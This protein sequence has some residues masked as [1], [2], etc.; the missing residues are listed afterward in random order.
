MITYQ[1]ETWEDYLRDCQELWKEHYDEIAVQKEKMAMKPFVGF[2][3]SLEKMGGL[4][5]I[6]VRANGKMV[7]YHITFIRPHT[8]YSDV[9]CGYVDAYFL[10]APYRKG[11]TGVKMIKEAER[12][13]KKRGVQK[14]FS[15]TKDFKNM[16]RIFEYLGWTLIEYA[17]AKYIGD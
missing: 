11:M 8:H 12:T 16:S 2:Y 6:T 4:H 15:A 1:V 17:F 3:E 7:G 10:S 9:L 14:M 5:I 13:L